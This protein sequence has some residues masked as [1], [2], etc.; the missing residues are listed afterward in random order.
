MLR[1][2]HSGLVLSPLV[3]AKSKSHVLGAPQS[4][5]QNAMQSLKLRPFYS[6]ESLLG[7][8]RNSGLFPLARAL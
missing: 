7:A 4:R 5:T 3:D 6:A 2:A 1:P 8:R